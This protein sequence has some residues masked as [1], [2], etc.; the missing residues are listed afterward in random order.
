MDR[1]RLLAICS[2]IPVVAGCTG[3]ST[4]NDVSPTRT[5]DTGSPTVTSTQTSASDRTG[6]TETPETC[7]ETDGQPCPPFATARHRAVCSHT[8][9]PNSASVYMDPHPGCSTLKNG[10]PGEEITL[11][12][13]NQSSQDLSF[14]P[15]SWRIWHG[16]GGEWTELEQ[17]VSG[18]GRVTVAAR[19]THTWSFLEAVESIQEEPALESGRYG[20][21]IGVSDP[22]NSDVRVALIA[23]VRLDAEH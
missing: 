5:S 6:G 21:E 15:Y 12:V 10:T 13:Y 14:N 3:Q 8:V 16:G 18:G 2:S 17:E 1:R 11:T 9:E 20:A 19:G 23:L 4:D 22:R 7:T